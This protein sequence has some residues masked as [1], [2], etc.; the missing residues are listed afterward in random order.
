MN[1]TPTPRTDAA[2]IPFHAIKLPYHPS[3]LPD[4][5]TRWVPRDKMA[6]LEQELTLA[7]ACLELSTDNTKA[8]LNSFHAEAK[9]RRSAEAE[10]DKLKKVL[11]GFSSYHVFETKTI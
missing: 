3:G 10:R 8:A 9:Q 7:R 4:Y 5:T 11:D 6:E 1:N 2:A